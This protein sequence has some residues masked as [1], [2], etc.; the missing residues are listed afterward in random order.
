[1]TEDANKEIKEKI[2]YSARIKFLNEIAKPLAS[3][4]LTK[5]IYKLVKKAHKEKTYL[6]VGLKEVQRRIRR[7]ETGLV[8]FAGDVTPI[9]IMSHM[10]GICENKGLF[11]CYVPSREDLGSSMGVKRS[12]VMV[13]I[14][15]HEDYADLYDECSSEI[16]GLP[17]DFY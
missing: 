11:Y 12:A 13:L 10:P 15:K 3:K 9:D 16:K 1:M 14:R 6:R 5:K 8:I 7:G 4:T 17:L 2:P